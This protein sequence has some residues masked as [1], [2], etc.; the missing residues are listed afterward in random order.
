MQVDQS[1]VTGS[2]GRS[3]LS[4]D[5]EE[6]EEEEGDGMFADDDDDVEAEDKAR[7]GSPKLAVPL[8]PPA[9]GDDA[10][11]L[12]SRTTLSFKARP[13]HF[14]GPTRDLTLRC[15][16]RLHELSWRDEKRAVLG[17]PGGKQ[18]LA[19]HEEPRSSLAGETCHL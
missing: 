14:A 13:E 7:D 11:L 15:E 12:E 10:H 18:H 4:S 2:M 6:E 9:E 19:R 17:G 1:L 5:D 8:V 3:H 16:A